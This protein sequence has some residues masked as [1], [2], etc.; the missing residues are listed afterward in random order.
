MSF[1][2][3]LQISKILLGFLKESKDSRKKKNHSLDT[4][5]TMHTP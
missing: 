4:I 5:L 2:R 3:R 1:D